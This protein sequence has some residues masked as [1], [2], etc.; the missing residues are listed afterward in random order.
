[1]SDNPAQTA[2][3]AKDLESWLTKLETGEGREATEAERREIRN[4]TDAAATGSSTNRIVALFERAVALLAN[5]VAGRSLGLDGARLRELAARHAEIDE[6]GVSLTG[7]LEARA[8]VRVATERIEPY[9]KAR[10]AVPSGIE[11]DTMI[12]ANRKRILD[13]FGAGE[14]D[15]NR[16]AW[17]LRHRI[18]DADTLCELLELPDRRREEIRRVTARFRMG[19]TPEYASLIEPG[20]E[21]DPVLIQCVPQCAEMEN[22]GEDIAAIAAHHS[23]ARLIDQIYPQV[24]A[25]K[26]TNACAMYCRHCLRPH[27]I[28]FKDRFWPDDAFDEAI[29]YIAS[30]PAVRDVLL[31]GGDALALPNERL[32]RLLE[33]LD[34]I[35]HVKV[36]RIGTRM[37]ATVPQRFD[38]ALLDILGASSA[39]KPIRL[40]TQINTAREITCASRAKLAAIAER[41]IVIYDQIV[42]LRGVNDSEAKMWRLFETLQEARVRPYYVFQ[43]SYRNAQF[44]HLR[45]PIRV[46]RRI[47]GGAIG[48]LSGD[49]R[50]TYIAAAGGKVPLHEDYLLRR[51]GD[52]AVLC[53]PWTGEE[54]A[55][56][57]APDRAAMNEKD[58]S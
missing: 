52:N 18:E 33:R 16:Y 30:N 38:D 14:D 24:V 45:V 57:D 27:D 22:G 41:G 8:G 3:N 56:P 35:E 6:H 31:T 19:V 55:Y 46:G 39:R 2:W 32:R 20:R 48:N 29:E 5:G 13:R 7:R 23:P 36:K 25:V 42:L 11:L 10:G 44:R 53:R 28:G 37:P 17:Q 54:V 12:R 9:L 4:L 15:W 21:D 47:V 50:P 26:V 49:L 34:A 58:W 51:E 1:M 43:C 40:V